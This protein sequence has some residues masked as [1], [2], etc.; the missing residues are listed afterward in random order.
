MPTFTGTTV[1]H[2]SQIVCTNL[3]CQE[4]FEKQLKEETK[5]REVMRVKKE[6]NKSARKAS[7]LMQANKAKKSKS[8]I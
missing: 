2:Y 1:V 3:V 6:E 8:R 4:T 5:K 7:S